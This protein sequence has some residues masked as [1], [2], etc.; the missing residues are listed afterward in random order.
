MN[1]F[2][3]AANKHTLQVTSLRVSNEWCMKPGTK[4]REEERL[5]GRS[6]EYQGGFWPGY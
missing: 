3:K 4:K 2:P 6:L 5:I 1:V